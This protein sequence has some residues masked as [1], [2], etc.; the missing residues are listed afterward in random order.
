MRGWWKVLSVIL[1][2]YTL[3]GGFL[4]EVARLPIL[5]E[6]IRNL[7]FHVTMWFGMIILLTASMVYAIKNL[8]SGDPMHDVISSELIRVST[9]MGLIGCATGAVWAKYT[10]GAWWT[11]DAKLN[12]A[13]ITV[14][15]YVAYLILR[16]SVE[17]DSSRQRLSGVYAIFA[18]VLMI[19]FII[20]LPRMTDSLHPGNGGNSSFGN[21]DVDNNMRRVFYPAIIGWT[22]FALWIASLRIRL[23]RVELLKRDTLLN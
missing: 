4:F 21:L 17:D 7:Y 10:W 20:I 2:L 19:V 5:N 8:N 9:V 3:I 16:S 23:K 12:G 1:V 11:W 18:Y 22:L 14:L 15:I 13:A 6:T